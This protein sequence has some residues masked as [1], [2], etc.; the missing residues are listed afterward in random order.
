MLVKFLRK[1]ENWI[2][3]YKLEF[4]L[5]S[6][7]WKRNFSMICLSILQFFIS[8]VRTALDSQERTV[9]VGFRGQDT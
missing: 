6:G 4:T 7:L 5:T 3:F 1:Y 2:C 9:I 8:K